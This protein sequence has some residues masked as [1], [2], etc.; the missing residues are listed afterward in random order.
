MN[1]IM[2]QL[3][4]SGDLQ[5]SNLKN[6][7]LSNLQYNESFRNSLLKVQPQSAAP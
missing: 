2:K 5:I 1:D 3:G 4:D 6:S 7:K